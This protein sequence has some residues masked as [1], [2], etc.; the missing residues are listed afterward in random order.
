ME[1]APNSQHSEIQRTSVASLAAHE[2]MYESHVFGN[3]RKMRQT[4]TQAKTPTL[5]KQQH[6]P[7]ANQKTTRL[8]PLAGLR[9]PLEFGGGRN[10]LATGH[11]HWPEN[12]PPGRGA[13]TKESSS[14]VGFQATSNTVTCLFPNNNHA[15]QSI[16]TGRNQPPPPKNETNA[17]ASAPWGGCGR[18]SPGGSSTSSPLPWPGRTSKRKEAR[19][20]LRHIHV[21]KIR[22]QESG[23]QK[24]TSV[25]Q[26]VGFPLKGTNSEKNKDTSP[27][28]P[29]WS[30]DFV[31]SASS[32]APL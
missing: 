20:R 23:H 16:S 25:F 18:G 27:L 31:R 1:R 14:V 2:A 21:A 6:P 13:K 19:K 30:T 3:A 32:A 4:Q 24:W 26:F 7:S 29:F 28:R 5:K 8:R 9:T 12:E 11:L 15:L 17:T 10:P 22:L